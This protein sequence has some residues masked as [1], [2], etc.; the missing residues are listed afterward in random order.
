M[1]HS[2]IDYYIN[3][4]SSLKHI[5]LAK[6]VSNY[7]KNGEHISK[8]KKTNIIGFFKY[9]KHIDF[10]NFCHEKLFLYVPFEQRE[11]TL[12]HNFSTWQDAYAFYQST[13]QNNEANFTY[14]INTT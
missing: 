2:I 6:L 9:N 11:D 8:R 13:I 5:F 14:N 12:K 1:C 4:P 10:E 7:K 3:C